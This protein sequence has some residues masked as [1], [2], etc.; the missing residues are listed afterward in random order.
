MKHSNS[1]RSAGRD[2]AFGRTEPFPSAA[3]LAADDRFLTE[4]AVGN[5]D[6]S[7]AGLYGT[8]AY[9][10][11]LFVRAG[12][13]A[14]ADVPPV[15]ELD[16]DAVLGRFDIVDVEALPV[17]DESEPIGAARVNG[18]DDVPRV[19]HLRAVGPRGGMHGGAH[20]GGEPRRWW[21]PTRVGSAMLGAAASFLLVAGGIGAIQNAGPGGVLW[22]V[23][24]S[25]FGGHTAEVELASMLEEADAA[26]AAGDVER[27]EELLA[28]AQE[29]MDRVNEADRAIMEERMRQ[30]E[31]RVRTV[32]ATPE[33]VTSNRTE[34]RVETRTRAPE[35]VSR[36][37]GTVT[38]TETATET[39]T[40]TV[41]VAPSSPAPPVGG[42]STPFDGGVESPVAP[43]VAGL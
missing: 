25:L 38:Q 32:T 31:A 19:G 43:A 29:L 34:T 9:L 28:R 21:Y 5:D 7:G 3:E 14:N 36:T 2:T 15:P 22:P 16:L 4:L 11:G 41:T 27:A 6:S 12:H 24:Q 40:E 17:D 30:S 35:T 13:H 10:A 1:S 37:P 20:R 26:S 18:V 42:E 23:K 33:T 39:V 8:D